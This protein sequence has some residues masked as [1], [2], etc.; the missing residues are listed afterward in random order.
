MDRAASP[1]TRDGTGPTSLDL[2]RRRWRSLRGG[3]GRRKRSV[4]ELLD[5][6]RGVIVQ[7][8][9]V[10]VSAGLSWALAQWWLDSPAPIWAPITAALI[11][12]LTVR[13]SVRDAAEKVL[14][15]TVGILVA[16]WLGS[17]I[18]LHAWSIALITGIGFLAGKVLRLGPGAAAQ[19]PINGLFVLAL[20]SAGIEQRFLDTLIGAGVAVVVNFVVVPP[21]HVAAATRSVADLA[22][23]IVDS[24]TALSRGIARPWPSRDALEWLLDARALGRLSASAEAE[25]RKADQSL[26]LHPTRASWAAAMVR[27]RQANETLQV[28]ELQNRTITRTVRDLSVKIEERDGRQLPMPMASAMLLATADSIEAFAHTVLRAEKGA[29]LDVVAGPARRAV[30]IAR[31]RIDAINAD[32][33]DMLAANLSRGVFLG[34]LVIETGRILD[35]L[36]AGLTALEEPAAER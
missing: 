2:I 5:I 10:A 21:N 18:G 20:G 8:V 29:S 17:L 23:G 1:D 34:T 6:D 16:I 33:A 9:K 22:D 14:A 26:S 32:L 12:L 36:C 13:A 7:T 11:A 25:V 31:E 19:I 15:V 30:A 35:E 27:L 24:M 4:G 3:D 28:V